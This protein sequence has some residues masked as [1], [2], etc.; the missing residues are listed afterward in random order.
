[1][2]KSYFVK[3]T[4]DFAN[5]YSLVYT[6]THEQKADAIADGYE[7]IPRR[8]AEELAAQERFRR[9]YDPSFA[10]HADADIFP[11]GVYADF[12]HYPWTRDGYLIVR[13]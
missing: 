11:F 12:N 8:R 5:C 10:Y 13:I 2:R 3:H 9:K 6:E 1:M 4:R 7:Q